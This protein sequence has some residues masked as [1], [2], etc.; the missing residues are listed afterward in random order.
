MDSALV[1]GCYSFLLL[2]ATACAVAVLCK[3]MRCP[4]PLRQLSIVVASVQSVTHLELECGL[5][6]GVGLEGM[7]ICCGLVHFT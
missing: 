4:R 3:V 7:T 2:F 5:S 1:A 6:I